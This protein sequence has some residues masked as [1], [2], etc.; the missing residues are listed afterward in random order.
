M[1]IDPDI[2]N[3]FENDGGLRLESWNEPLPRGSCCRGNLWLRDCHGITE[4][5]NDLDVAG[6]LNL[7]GTSI[8]EVPPGI[9]VGASLFLEDCPNLTKV[10]PGIWVADA[11]SLW[12]SSITE[13]PAGLDAGH[14]CAMNCDRLTGLPDGASYMGSVSLSGS[15]IAGLPEGLRVG[16]DLAFGRCLK[17]RTLPAVMS[18]DGNLDLMGCLAW[19][20]QIGVGVTVGGRVITT[21]HQESGMPLGDWRMA[22]PKGEVNIG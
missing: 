21:A 22:H 18:V 16:G 6:S 1:N 12:G 4:I 13:L 15:A 14:L 19:D 8:T 20:G 11:I 10:S 2:I 7:S 5:P 3:G 17:L 9:R